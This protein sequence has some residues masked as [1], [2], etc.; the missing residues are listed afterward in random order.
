MKALPPMHGFKV[1]ILQNP[2]KS[3]FRKNGSRNQPF[4]SRKNIHVIMAK[5]SSLIQTIT[6]GTGILLKKESPVQP[7]K[8]VADCTAGRESHPAL[9]I[10]FFLRRLL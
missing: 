9:K 10:L 5:I 4:R 6:V 7:P 8:R 3:R 1:Y 2:V